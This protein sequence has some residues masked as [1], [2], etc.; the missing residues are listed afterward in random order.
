M[1][2]L[3]LYQVKLLLKRIDL[4]GS[5]IGFPLQTNQLQPPYKKTPSFTLEVKE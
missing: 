2:E 5:T 1:V 4:N 3:N